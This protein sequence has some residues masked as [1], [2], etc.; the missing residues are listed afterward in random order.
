MASWVAVW[1]T[2]SGELPFYFGAWAHHVLGRVILGTQIH[3]TDLFTVSH[4]HIMVQI[5]Y[6]Q[7]DELNFIWVPSV[8]LLR[9]YVPSL[10]DFV[11]FKHPLIHDWVGSVDGLLTFGMVTVFTIII[12]AIISSI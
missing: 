5:V 1:F 2:L 4:N 9:R 8:C 6:C 12:F 11:I 7:V 10:F 3:G